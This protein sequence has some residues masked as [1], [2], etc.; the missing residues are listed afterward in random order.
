M[1][2]MIFGLPQAS[3]GTSTLLQLPS[4]LRSLILRWLL[5]LDPVLPSFNESCRDVNN[6]AEWQ[7]YVEANS[8]SAQLLATCQ[9]LY[10]EGYHVLYMENTL[11]IFCEYRERHNHRVSVL[12]RSYDVPTGRSG[13]HEYDLRLFEEDLLMEA[14]RLSEE[15]AEVGKEL[16]VD[17]EQSGQLESIIS[18]FACV[19]VVMHASDR[20]DVSILCR[21]L[22]NF[23]RSK[24]VTI[25]ITSGGHP[26]LE[27]FS[28]LS[29]LRCASLTVDVLPAFDVARY[30][31]DATSDKAVVDTIKMFQDTKCGLMS[32]EQYVDGDLFVNVYEEEIARMEDAAFLH[33]VTV[34]QD[35]KDELK[36][37]R[38][39]WHRRWAAQEIQRFKEEESNTAK[40][41]EDF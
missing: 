36:A 40:W 30:A 37:A 33:Q 3:Q 41:L 20:D 27:G 21:Y 28:G 29:W 26:Q 23:L 13:W 10:S 11:S 5:K 6:E 22:H 32:H 17:A 15:G 14:D 39:D 7:S 8:L 4:E 12:N 31:C 9:Q 25:R 34:F 1:S 16:L 19:R 35:V 24:R 18:R 38:V 2:T